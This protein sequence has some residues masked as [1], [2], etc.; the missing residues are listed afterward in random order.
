MPRSSKMSFGK[1]I[2]MKSSE[3]L[4]TDLIEPPLQFAP[5][6]V[7]RYRRI[8]LRGPGIGRVNRSR[9]RSVIH[10]LHLYNTFAH[11]PDRAALAVRSN[12]VVVTLSRHP[13]EVAPEQL[14]R[15]RT[16]CSD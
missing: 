13:A 16:S 2:L 12:G 10:I 4:F 11:R 6:S 7:G 5:T 15:Y 14:D 1:V 3:T 9:T 8:N